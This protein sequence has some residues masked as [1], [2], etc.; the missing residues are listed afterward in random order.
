[1]KGRQIKLNE[2]IMRL[3]MYDQPTSQLLL[4]KGSARLVHLGIFPFFY[5]YA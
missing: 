5:V 1:M 3:L 4:A 2:M